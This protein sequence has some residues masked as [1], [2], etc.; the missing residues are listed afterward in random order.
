MIILYYL[1]IGAI[2]T[3]LLD[4]LIHASP[5]TE[6]LSNTERVAIILFYPIHVVLFIIE[7]VKVFKKK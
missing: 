1:L 2:Y 3:F 4:I 5:T 7:I 6:N